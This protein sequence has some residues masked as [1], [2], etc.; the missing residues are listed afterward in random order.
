MKKVEHEARHQQISLNSLSNQIFKNYIEWDML[1][2]KAG[3]IPVAK[4]VISELF[5][6]LSKEEVVK[7]AQQVGKDIMNDLILFM[8]HK[9][10]LNSF[11]SWLEIWLKKNSSAGFSHDVEKNNTHTC[12]IRH[13]LGEN[14][15]L[16]HKTV[17]ELIFKET[18][19][20]PVQIN[21]TNSTLTLSFEDG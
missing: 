19:N 3:M 12:M 1:S 9:I 20:I 17:L 7:L 13:D 8:K 15:S 5:G 4:R 16:Y 10:D 11:L 6:R 21:I 14:W 2:P 18:L